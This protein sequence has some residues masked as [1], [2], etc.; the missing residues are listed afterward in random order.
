MTASITR[1]PRAMSDHGVARAQ[2]GGHG[3]DMDARFSFDVA[4]NILEL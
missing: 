1:A 4:D 3:G 2:V